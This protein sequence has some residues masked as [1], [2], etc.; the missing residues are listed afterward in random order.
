MEVG[1]NIINSL[2]AGSGIDSSSIVKQLVEIEKTFKQ[3]GIDDDRKKLDS[4]IS[5]YGLLKSALATLQDSAKTLQNSSTFSTKSADFTDS[6]A[7]VPSALGDDAQ[8]GSY[9]LE[10]LAIAQAQSL[11]TAAAFSSASDEVGKGVLTFSFGEW[12]AGVGTPPDPPEVFTADTSKDSFDITIDDS[13]NSL[14]GLRDAINKADKGVQASIINDGSDYRLVITAESGATNELQITVAEDGGT[15]SNTDGSDLSRFAFGAGVAGANQQMVQQQSGADSSLVVNGLA[16]T[17]SSNKIDDVIQG[18]TFNVIK[19]APGEV[20][21]V[22]VFE[23]KSTA[24]QT[25]RDFVETFN[26]FL[27]AVEPLTGLNEETDEIGSLSRDATTKSIMTGLRNIIA[28]AVPGSSGDFSSLATIGIRTEKDGTLVISEDDPATTFNEDIFSA[29]FA[30]NYEDVRALFVPEATSSNS[31][32]EVNGY[33]DNTVAGSYDVVITQ[34]PSKGQLVGAAA[35]GTLIADLVGAGAND[36]D[37]TITVDGVA[38]GTIS[39]TPGTY[40]DRDA[41]AAH[42]QSQINAD[43]LLSAA[44][45]DVN[46]VWNTDHFE[47]TSRSFGGSSN[48]AVQAVGASAGDLGLAAGVGTAGTDVKGTF[49][50]V[51]GFGV[52]DVLLAKLNTDAEGLKL[53]VEPGTASATVNFSSGFGRTLDDLV[54]QLLQSNGILDERDKSLNAQLEDLDEDQEV[55]DRRIEAYEARL[56]AQYQAMESIINSL[57]QSKTMLNGIL[58]RLPFTSSSS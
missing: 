9:T 48:V 16:V 58:D 30:D 51:E 3:T 26:A 57:N 17:R 11:S 20:M 43:S 33:G 23:D 56:M 15:P 46:V 1:G 18:F 22:N 25:V 5:D 41:L 21:S 37:F 6:T 42:I 14:T 28:Q 44:G 13:N 19:A 36:Y 54:G 29:A 38:S 50:G 39:L 24:E 12:D 31:G 32:I 47:I 40:A 45:A 27:K 55:L 10:V 49:N 35:S 8:V 2:G 52:G 53:I 4:Q 34:D 7:I